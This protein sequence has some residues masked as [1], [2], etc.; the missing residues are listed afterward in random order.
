MRKIKP[1]LV[2]SAL[3]G[4]AAP[5]LAQVQ[6]T[7]PIIVKQPKHKFDKFKGSVLSATSAAIMV[8]GTDNQRIVRTFQYSP[9]MHEKMIH[10]IDQGG[11][12]Y[13]DKVT[14]ITEP[15]SEVAVDVKGHPSKPH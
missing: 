11:Y 12:Q 2:L 8:Q 3:L 7:A 13:G 1:A 15:G 9:K 10:I 5:A 4:A 14:V 6:T